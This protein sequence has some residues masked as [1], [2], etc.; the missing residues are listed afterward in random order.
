MKVW[1]EADVEHMSHGLLLI[2]TSIPLGNVNVQM[3]F[4]ADLAKMLETLRG[5][6]GYIKFHMK[7]CFIREVDKTNPLLPLWSLNV[8]T[9]CQAKSGK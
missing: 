4:D 8:H 2:N 3:K 9:K 6:H 1:P 5:C 7:R